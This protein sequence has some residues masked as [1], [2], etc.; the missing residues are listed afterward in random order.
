MASVRHRRRLGAFRALAVLAPLV[1]VTCAVTAFVVDGPWPRLA[2]VVG[3]L[4]SMTLGGVVMKLERRLRIEVA[5]VRAEQAAE[6]SHVHARYYDEH[7][8][9]TDHMVGLLDVA[10]ERIDIM[11]GRLDL[12]EAE[13]AQ[14]RSARPGASTPS[15]ELARLAEGAE[16][17]DLW[18][19]LSD[20]PT[21]VD[22]IKWDD[23]NRTLVAADPEAKGAAAAHDEIDE[24]EERTA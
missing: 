11:R 9:F 20:A 15:T 8:D 17:N 24:R 2:A 4:I 1:A 18:P 19:D 13:I 10:S 5:A 12:L 3:A 14:A 16:W 22:L 7:R 6:Y 21:V 23:K